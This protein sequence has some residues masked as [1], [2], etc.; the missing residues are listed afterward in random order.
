[1]KTYITGFLTGNALV[2]N[3]RVDGTGKRLQSRSFIIS[4]TNRHLTK[5]GVAD[6]VMELNPD[7]ETRKDDRDELGTGG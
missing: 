7:G 5:R 4:D 6:M 1:M 2:F 3:R